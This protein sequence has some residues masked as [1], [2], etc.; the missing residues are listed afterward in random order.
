MHVVT[1]QLRKATF[2]KSGVGQG[3]ESTMYGLELSE[4]IKDQKTGEKSY[5]N[6][7]ALLFAKS[8]AHVDHYN[9][10]LVEGNW[11]SLSCAKLKIE[12]REHNGKEYITL[13]MESARIDASGY[14]DGPSSQ[15]QGGYQQQAPQQQGGYQNQP[16]QGG[17]Q[18]QAP[19]QNQGGYQQQ[20]TQQGG[21][22]Q[23]FKQQPT[24][25]Q[26][27]APDLDDGWDDDI[28]F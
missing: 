4:M 25:Q 21:Q 9:K 13:F 20:Q 18:Q 11:V 5:T 17:Y 12:K 16:Q 3:G 22:Q 8:Q 7:K 23:G 14:I 19:Q 6:Y 1:G 28:P 2:I 10:T 27:K 24:Q 26:A 15:Q